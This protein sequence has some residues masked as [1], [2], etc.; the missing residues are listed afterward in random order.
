MSIMIRSPDL[1]N[2]SEAIG[3]DGKGRIWVVTN[4]RQLKDDEEVGMNV[5]MS[6]D[7]GQR[8]MTMTPSGNTDVV[9][10][11]AFQFEVF[12]SDGIL[13]KIIPL[14]HFVDTMRIYDNKIYIVD[15]L[16]GMQVFEYTINN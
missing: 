11:D 12:D 9:E 1:N 16:R 6:I 10:T 15:Q 8:S 2:V 5:N 14:T 4:R 7:N 3:V 13:L